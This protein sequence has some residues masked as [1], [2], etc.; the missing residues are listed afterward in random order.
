MKGSL[1][2]KKKI[3]PA[4]TSLFPKIQFIVATHSSFVLN[5]ISNAVIYDL[6]KQIRL[7]DVSHISANKLNDNYFNFS[8]EY[9]EQIKKK[10]DEFAE[11][12]LLYKDKKLDKTSKKRLA[13]LEIDLDEVTPYIS[14][15]YFKKF[16][17]N[18]KYRSYPHRK[19]NKNKV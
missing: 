8:P 1:R 18:Q 14:D 10:V 19:K 9:V 16:K 4:L 3:L 12:I 15:E 7:E 2:A 5:S 11:L 17:D 6:E 13:E